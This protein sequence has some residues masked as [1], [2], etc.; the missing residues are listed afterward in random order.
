MII[1]GAT[2]T[3]RMA[4]IFAI[5]F[6][7]AACGGGGGGGDGF[8]DDSGSSSKLKLK[9][10]LLDTE[11]NKTE[12]VTSS[13][14]GILKVTASSSDIVVTTT[15]DIGLVFPAS[16]TALTNSDGVATFQIEAGVERGAGTITSTAQNKNGETL[17]GTLAFQVGDSGLRLGYFDDDG[18]FI[19]NEISIEPETTLAAGGNAQFSV[20][21]L[22]QNGNRVTTAENVRFNSGCIA[23][24]QATIS[25]ANPVAT[26]NGQASTLYT[27]KSCSG[28]DSITASLVGAGAQAM[29]SIDIASREANAV[30]FISAEPQLI[31]LRGTGG[32]NRDETSN[33]VFKV[34][35]SG[36]FPLQGMTVDFTLSTYVGGLSL[37][38]SSSLSDNEGQVSVTVSAGDV[39]TAVRVIATVDDG[40]GQPVS[41]VSDLLTVTTGLPDAN[42]ISLS[43]SGGF[44]VENGMS[45]DGVARTLT[46]SMADKFNNPVVDGTAAVFTTEY[47]AI[48]GSCFT[49]GGTCSVEWRSQEPRFPT[50][51][52]DDFVKTIADCPNSGAC[53]QDLGY[54]RGGR[55]TILVHTIGE[56]SFID[57]NG[58]GIMDEA[59]KDL[60]VNLTEAFIDNNEDDLFTPD[61][62]ECLASPMGSA[63]CIAG[64]EETFIDFN[65]NDAYD[66]N[67]DPA[68]YNGLLCPPEGDGVWCSRDLLHVW[69]DIVVTLSAAPSWDINLVGT[70]AYI[71]DFFNNAP[72]ETSGVDVSA[73]GN[74][75]VLGES[76]FEVPNIYSPGAY[77]IP[78]QTAAKDPNDP[79]SGTFSITLS[80]KE[81][82]DYTEIY[83]CRR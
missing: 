79:E 72:P 22:D 32:Q 20:V 66:R 67:D 47:G 62:P 38:K 52:G 45:M 53:P 60:F 82:A 51:T 26:V 4:V 76:S 43:V 78:V 8:I 12:T 69:D 74:C 15:T 49:T 16:G 1:R 71:A 9:L 58:N 21:I 41:T 61:L 3:G 56:E 80:P 2:V 48:V 68:V 46:V 11:G 7:V 25:P 34:I 39:A 42:S 40:G 57:R 54:T 10:V 30:L 44:V 27:A 24:G 29:G 59:E 18:D 6:A 75:E 28:G 73:D 83:G 63:Q 36:G 14:P 33:V 77:G 31:V 50:Q 65:N 81:G 5:L 35:D 70:T 17:T 13:A 23:A 64:F 55:S 19:E 37:S